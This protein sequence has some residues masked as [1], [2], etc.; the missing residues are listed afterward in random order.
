M[1]RKASGKKTR[2]LRSKLKFRQ[3]LNVFGNVILLK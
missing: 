3:I 2:Q 1:N